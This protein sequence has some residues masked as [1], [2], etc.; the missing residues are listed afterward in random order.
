MK[1]IRIIPALLALLLSAAAV[2]AQPVELTLKEA[3]NYAVKNNSNARKA[4]LEGRK[5]QYKVDEVRSQ[6]LPQ[7]TGNAGLVYNPIIGKFVTDMGTFTMGKTWNAQA[8]VQ[9]NQQLFNQQVFTGLKAARSS[10]EFYQLNAEL[11]EEQVIEQVSALYY[12]LLLNR[13]QLTVIDT[14]ISNTSQVER[15]IANQF[16]NGLARRIDLD[17]VRVGLTN[18]KTQREQLDNAV[19]QQANALKVY[20]GMPVSTSIIIPPAELRNIEPKVVT[21]D[22]VNYNNRIE[23]KLVKKQEELLRLQ[24]KAYIAEYYPSLALSGTY[25]YTGLS[26]KF[27][28]FK[29]GGTDYWYDASAITLGLR[30]PIFNGF[31]TRARINQAKIDILENQENERNLVQNLN[32]ANENAKLQMQSNLTTI[33]AQ[34][35]NVKLA[36]DVYFSTQ[37]NYR[38]G[39][40]SLTDLLD[41]EGSLTQAKNSYNQALLN[42]K[43][44]EIQL[45]KSQGNIK[46]LLN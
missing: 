13:E 7:L 11:T 17:R 25:N 15:T 27:D 9:L 10:E 32:L 26:N 29:K 40:A 34:R 23:Y 45:I 3:L 28:L 4:R 43:I 22:T 30:V 20:I 19:T 18:L 33:N 1:S 5:G 12:Q 35:A 42:Y 8:G 16:K 39:L 36:E 38:N 24:E 14:N 46:S 41:A 21:N 37:N 31:A 6:A 44:T 2:Q